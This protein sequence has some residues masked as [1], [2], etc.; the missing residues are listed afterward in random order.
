MAESTFQAWSGHGR[1][2]FRMVHRSTRHA[3]ALCALLSAADLRSQWFSR[4]LPEQVPL[5]PA[6][7]VGVDAG[8]IDGD[9]DVDLVFVRGSGTT[10]PLVYRN[11]GMGRFVNDASGMAPLPNGEYGAVRLAD[12]DGDGDLDFV[13]TRR[14]GRVVMFRNQGGN[15]TDVTS[16]A[17]PNVSVSSPAGS[18]LVFDSD[19][20]GHQDLLS[21]ADG[22]VY[23]FLNN[24]LG[25]FVDGSARVP[26][27]YQAIAEPVATDIDGDGDQDVLIARTSGTASERHLLLR[28]NGSGFFSDVSAQLLPAFGAV[29]GPGGMSVAA[30]DLDGDGDPD[31]VVGHGRS[32]FAVYRNAAGAFVEFASWSIAGLDLSPYHVYPNRMRLGDVD[33]DG[34]LDLVFDGGEYGRHLFLNDGV[35]TFL[36]APNGMLPQARQSV[37][38]TLLVDLDGDLDLDLVQATPGL[39]LTARPLE[40]NSVAFND[41]RGRFLDVGRNPLP[42]TVDETLSVL[43]ID[44]DRDGFDDLVHGIGIG[45][46]SQPIGM[47]FAYRSVGDGTFVLQERIGFDQNLGGVAVLASADVDGDG[48]QDVYAGTWGGANLLFMNQNGRLVLRNAIPV[49][50]SRASA[51]VFGDFDRDGDQDLI[52][53]RVAGSPFG[54]TPQQTMFWRNDGTGVFADATTGSL[55]PSLDRANVLVAFDLQRD[56]DLDLFVGNANG[57]NPPNRLFVNGGNADFTDESATRLPAGQFGEVFGAVAADFDGNGAD[58]LFVSHL[59]GTN[60]SALLLDSGNGVFADAMDAWRDLE[61]LDFRSI[62]AWDVDHDG[63]VDLVNTAPVPKVLRNLPTNRFQAVANT[64]PPIEPVQWSPQYPAIGDFDGDGEPDLLHGGPWLSTVHWNLRHRISVPFLPK[65]GTIVPMR[66]HA[67]P[68]HNVAPRPAFFA[69]SLSRLR[70]PHPFGTLWLDPTEPISIQAALLPA[71][72][73][74]AEVPLAIGPAPSLQGQQFT[75]QGLVLTSDLSWAEFTNP[76]TLTIR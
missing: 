48:W 55:P 39:T 32:R 22:R 7:S 11:L 74:V 68:G 12:L 53:A 21:V 64:A 8:D 29:D 6:Q 23:L 72:V 49:A 16:T 30:G 4:L 54:P 43:A 27:T 66:I 40:S 24:G 33:R 58:D 28:N 18:I 34:D 45:G 26:V 57:G 76:L 38:Q 67:D 10:L 47:L 62:A 41:G 61:F 14:F 63:R 35:G 20:D 25:E 15:F 71:P 42:T 75:V 19:R 31:F 5:H 36:P 59:A 13:A 46:S 73:G 17:S 44:L 69:A 51:A 1:I 50:T 37:R 65:P 70:A 52:T 60:R 56:G 2:C 9:G 3:L